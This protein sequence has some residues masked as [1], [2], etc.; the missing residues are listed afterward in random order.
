MDN[1]FKIIAVVGTNSMFSRNKRLLEYMKRRYEVHA[2]IELF[3]LYNIEPY[4]EE[5]ALSG[6]VP[7][8]IKELQDKIVDADGVIFGI[9]EHFNSVMSLLQTT[10]EWLSSCPFVLINKRC[11]VIADSF[12]HLE[13]EANSVQ[14]LLLILKSKELEADV[15]YDY[16]FLLND[17][18]N[19]FD[20]DNKL[21]NNK[22][23]ETLDAFFGDFLEHMES[24]VNYG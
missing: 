22:T 20:E 8:R 23:V 19:A 3:E 21:R 1:R 10:L 15:I 9:T 11:M 5:K 4:N 17:S 2:E 14:T 18:R 13:V 6:I 16:V 12:T 24:G 7:E